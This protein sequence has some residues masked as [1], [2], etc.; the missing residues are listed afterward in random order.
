MPRKQR[1]K[2]SRKPQTQPGTAGEPNEQRHE[3]HPGNVEIERQA[4]QRGTSESDVEG[5]DSR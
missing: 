2:P 5:G 4:P 1:F 3:I